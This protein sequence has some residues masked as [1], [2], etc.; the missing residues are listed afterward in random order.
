MIG[1]RLGPWIIEREIGRGGMGAVYF[2]RRAGDAQPG[3]DRAAVKVLAAELAVEVGF[4]QR[5]QREIDILRQLDHPGIV[6]LFDAGNQDGR[7]WFAMEYVSGPS[8]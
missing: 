6:K 2:A 8:F 3:P 5:F 7:Y 1:V 4:Q